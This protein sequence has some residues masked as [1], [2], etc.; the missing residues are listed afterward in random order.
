MFKWVDAKEDGVYVPG[1]SKE[2]QI[3]LQSLSWAGAKILENSTENLHIE[4]TLKEKSSG[5]TIDV[6]L[7]IPSSLK[8]YVDYPS[9]VITSRSVHC[10]LKVNGLTDLLPQNST[11]RLGMQLT[12]VSTGQTVEKLPDRYIDDEYSPGIFKSLKYL[13]GKNVADHSYLAFKPN[14]YT[15]TDRAI[16][17]TIDSEQSKMQELKDKA[18]LSLNNAFNGFYGNDLD[19]KLWQMN[20]SFGGSGQNYF[21]KTNFTEFSFVV[22][23]DNLPEPSMSLFILLIIIIG[24]GLSLLVL[25]IFPISICL[26]VSDDFLILIL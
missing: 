24:S 18:S 23:L 4:Y 1:V 25:F 26:M 15:S 20:I 17:K 5:G 7:M 22:G 14:A 9:L 6:R 11:T 12:L 19:R 21:T 3:D 2:E 13:F 16:A 10:Q 8:K